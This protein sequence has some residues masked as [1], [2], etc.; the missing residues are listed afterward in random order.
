MM[1]NDN[2]IVGET[3]PTRADAVKN[4]LLLLETARQLFAAHGVE[5]VSMSAIAEA[6]GVGKG[7][8]YRHFENKTELCQALLDHDQRQ[9]QEATLRQLRDEPDPLKNL[10]WFVRTVVEFVGR[11]GEMLCAGAR[12][13]MLPP[14]E[15]PAHYWWRQTI[16]GLLEQLQAPGDRDYVADMLYVMLDARTI[17]YQQHI[18][19]YSQ[20]RII[21]GLT[22]L[23][24]RLLA[25]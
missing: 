6:A 22:A 19:G 8:L 20:E 13:G 5:A 23:L 9:L 11:N 1:M 10:R 18:L 21:E 25:Y 4:R 7:T 15:H 17:A 16:R 3:Q 12:S 24:D 2:L 14:L